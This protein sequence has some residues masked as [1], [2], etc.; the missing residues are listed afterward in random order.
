MSNFAERVKGASIRTDE[1]LGRT[2]TIRIVQTYSNAGIVQNEIDLLMGEQ[3]VERQDDASSP[4][5]SE[6]SSNIMRAVM[7]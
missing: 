4:D 2:G 6:I 5:N 1:L 3:I 7:A